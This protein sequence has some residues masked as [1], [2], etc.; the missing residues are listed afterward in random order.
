MKT[1]Q[2]LYKTM[3]GM[4]IAAAMLLGASS[5]FAQVK[6]GTNPTTI[7]PANNLEVEAANN[8]KVSANKT[9]GTLKVENKPLAAAT[10]SI[11]TRGADGELHQMSTARLLEQQNIAVTIFEGTLNSTQAIPVIVANNTLDQRINLTPRPGYAGVWDAVNKQI[12]L[13]SDG[14]YHF[15][16]GISCLGTGPGG[17]SV[18]VTRIFI[19]GSVAPFDYNYAPIS[20]A[21]GV[22]GSQAWSGEYTSGTKVSM[23]GYISQNTASPAYPANCTSGY[24]NVT[25]VK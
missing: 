24:F 18:L 23:N 11:V 1:N 20:S 2:L 21:F 25:K 8:K 10:D 5:A 3:G 6:I 7:D 22:S 15:E 9:T 14:Y 17:S 12:T 16:A 19:G 13:P 4:M